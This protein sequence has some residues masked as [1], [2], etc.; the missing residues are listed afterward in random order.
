MRSLKGRELRDQRA[1]MRMIFQ[2][3]FDSLNPRQKVVDI[4]ADPFRVHGVSPERGGLEREVLRLLDLV[5]LSKDYVN[6]E[7]PW[8]HVEQLAQRCAHA[9]FR[10]HERLPVYQE[11]INDEW[12]D[13]ALLPA[14]GDRREG[15]SRQARGGIV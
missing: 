7:A 1:Q 6:P 4:I 3:P 12:I 13:P 10:L 15:L 9:G 5:G 11:Y 8:P 2:K 14:V